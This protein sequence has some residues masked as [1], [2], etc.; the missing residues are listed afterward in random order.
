[1]RPGDVVGGKYR[2]DR[3]L[4]AGGMGIVVAAMQ[5]DLERPVALKF[6]LPQVLERTDQVARFSREARAAAKL[7]SEH[8][9]H[10]LDVGALPGGAP[11]IVMEYLEGEDLAR[12]VARRGPLPPAEAV[13]YLL[14][15]SEALAEAHA[16][17][18]VHRD[19]KPANL[20]LA[21]RTHGQPMLKVLDF[22]LSKVSAANEQVTSDSALL[23]SPLYMSPEQ[24]L[25]ARTVDAR[26]DIW[27]LGVTLYELLTATPPFPADKIPLLIAAVLHGQAEPI[28]ARRPDLAPELRAVVGRC[29]QRAAADRFADI[30]ELARA[31]APHGPPGS[32]AAVE[33]IEYLLRKPRPSAPPAVHAADDA[34]ADTKPDAR[35]DLV[36]RAKTVES[37]SAQSLTLPSAT[38]ASRPPS[39]SRVRVLAI[40]IGV[41]AAGIVG[42]MAATHGPHATPAGS[43]SASIAPGAPDESTPAAPIPAAVV[44]VAATAPAPEPPPS[45][46]PLPAPA[47]PIG[48][49]HPQSIRSLTH[50]APVPSASAAAAPSAPQP[51]PAA[52]VDPVARLKPL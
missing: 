41:A 9:A 22:G 10:V 16:L 12:T 15:A 19:L 32:Q 14:E 38:R 17:G 21:T 13:G 28:E 44:S 25:S 52:S 36:E 47:G 8:V 20:Y 49:V 40:G 23:G 1:V 45:A 34:V 48:S 51:A 35:M 4:G 37:S 50:T 42:V 33:R 27:S 46:H 6:L 26:S 18:I 43:A 39:S 3:I 11:Y 24:L 5:T 29:L 2:V 30:S 7:Q 31:L